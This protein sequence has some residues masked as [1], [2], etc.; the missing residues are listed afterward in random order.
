MSCLNPK[1]ANKA[2]SRGLCMGCYRKA[3]N[4]IDSGRVSEEEMIS[5]G[6]I[7]RAYRGYKSEWFEEVLAE[8]VV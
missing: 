4:M 1:C 2:H 8:K 6:R 5:A 3:T 7:H